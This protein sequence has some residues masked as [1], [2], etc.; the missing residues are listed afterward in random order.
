MR[1]RENILIR[2]L[3]WFVCVAWVQPQTACS[4]T[5][6]TVKWVE[7]QEALVLQKLQPRKIYV[8]VYADWCTWC[9]KMEATAYKDSLVVSVLN[10]DYYPVKFNAERKD[11]MEYKGFVFTFEPSGE[12]GFHQLASS[13]LNGEMSYPGLVILDENERRINIMRGY[14]TPEVL[15]GTLMYFADDGHLKKNAQQFGVG[16]NYQCKNPSHRHGNTSFGNPAVPGNN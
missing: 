13:L 9:A 5:A 2:L 6:D 12:H 14:R 4:Q 1:L 15:A 16:L 11:S 8:H 10:N 3:S 7:W